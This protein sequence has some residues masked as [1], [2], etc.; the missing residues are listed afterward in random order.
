MGRERRNALIVD[1]HP[2]TRT[3]VRNWLSALGFDSVEAGNGR[4][5]LAQ[6][7][8]AVP[9]LICLDLVLPEASGF[10]VCESIR[11]DPR[12]KNVMILALGESSIPTHRAFAGEAGADAFLPKPFTREELARRVRQM[13]EQR[14]RKGR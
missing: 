14:E 2:E 10:A 3:Q 6:L 12:L 9:D 1:D 7:S 13:F 8:Q 11:K 4:N 5:A